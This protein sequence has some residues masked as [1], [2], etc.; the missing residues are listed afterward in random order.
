MVLLE[1]LIQSG[2]AAEPRVAGHRRGLVSRALE[3]LRQ[4]FD[5]VREH[6]GVVPDSVERRCPSRQDRRERGKRERSLRHRRL[7]SSSLAGEAIQCGCRV[8][9]VAVASHVVRAQRFD[10]DQEDVRLR[11]RRFRWRPA[12]ERGGEDP[13]EE[14]ASVRARSAPG[15]EEAARRRRQ[16]REFCRGNCFEGGRQHLIPS[17]GVRC[18]RFG[19]PPRA[20]SEGSKRAEE[21]SE[22]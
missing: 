3:A 21:A 1:S 17:R 7:E 20:R 12:G 10:G 22:H 11:R 15:R 5:R 19:R 2:L 16:P 14:E 8:P 4:R 18:G 9:P 13:A 6:R